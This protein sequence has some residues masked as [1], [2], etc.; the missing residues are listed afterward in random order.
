MMTAD[1]YQQWKD[2][3]LTVAYHQFLRDF[4]KDLMERWATGSIQNPQEQIM[5]MAR[6][7]SLD[8]L[9]GLEDDFVSEFYRQKPKED[10]E[11]RTI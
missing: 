10:D 2:H 3:P 11:R 4:R 8:E 5:A 9:V 1:E 6:C 7:Q